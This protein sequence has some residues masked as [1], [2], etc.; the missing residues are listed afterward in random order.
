MMAFE[1]H[2]RDERRRLWD[3][4]PPPPPP[5]L[6]APTASMPTDAQTEEGTQGPS[7]RAGRRRAAARAGALDWVLAEGMT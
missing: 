7:S 3:L 4:E 6:P 1:G 5:E 2:W